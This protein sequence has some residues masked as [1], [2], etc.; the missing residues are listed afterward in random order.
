MTFDA[1][2]WINPVPAIAPDAGSGSGP[3][4]AAGTRA[5]RRAIIDV[6]TNSVKL[7][8]AEIAGSQVI[9]LC[10]QSEQ[11]RLGRN[12]YAHRCL[13]PQAIIQT[14]QAVARFAAAAARW[15]PATMRVVATSAVREAVN[16]QELLAAVQQTAGATVEIITGDQEAAWAFQG[17]SAD[18]R[19]ID[20]P[21]MVLD[22]GGGSSQFVV[23][24]NTGWNFRQSFPLGSVRL[25]EQMRFREPPTP[26][27]LAFCRRELNGFLEAQIRPALEPALRA[28]PSPVLL[29]GA[30]GAAS[31][32]ATMH[33]GLAS[34]VR[35]RIESTDLA[36]DHVV[37]RLERLWQT[38]LE[39]RHR[40]PGL[41]ADR[42]D[43]ILPGTA[44]YAAV[45]AA[46]GFACLRVSARGY[47]FGALMATG[48]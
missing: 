33:L 11:T 28:W 20:Q 31:I 43:V 13:Q 5:P 48:S 27:G 1:K 25:L 36:I 45:M 40:I 14:A 32:L 15:Q 30:G 8:V 41:P 21:I 23:G 22:V 12:F 4:A 24:R 35:E 26:A 46:F 3:H 16:S 39:E 9:P 7:L 19:F 2:G 37:A 18:P 17:V 47:R 38:S 29:V 42:A 10:E 44:I 6:G 34:F